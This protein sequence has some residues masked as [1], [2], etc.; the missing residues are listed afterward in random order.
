LKNSTFSV[1]NSIAETLIKNS[2]DFQ[3]Y[4]KYKD[5]I[6]ILNDNN[7]SYFR[8]VQANSSSHLYV[9]LSN[10]KY[11]VSNALYSFL[12]L[13]LS[14]DYDGSNNNLNLDKFYTK[15]HV[16]KEC[17]SLFADNIEVFKDDLIIE[18]SA[19]NGS[20]MAPLGELQCKS[21][22]IDIEPENEGIIKCDF[23]K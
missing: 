18:P 19:G 15:T 8:I 22:F 2:D 12:Y 11:R 7:I 17:V 21:V 23:L 10:K 20:F 5:V 16:A 3:S 6:F 1:S 9:I 13:S 4:T 14:E